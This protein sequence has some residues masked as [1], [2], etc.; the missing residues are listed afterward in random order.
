MKRD[1]IPPMKHHHEEHGAPVYFADLAVGDYFLLGN[2]R[3]KL[4][5]TP[6]NRWVGDRR[7]GMVNSIDVDTGT[8]SGVGDQVQVVRLA[9]DQPATAEEPTIEKR[10]ERVE[11]VL[12]LRPHGHLEVAS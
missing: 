6:V 3:R 1:T 7:L 5:Q 2:V 9:G 8:L 12:G 11:R 10:L 4:P